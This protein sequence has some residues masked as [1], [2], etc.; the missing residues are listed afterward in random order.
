MDWDKW[1]RKRKE[2]GKDNNEDEFFGAFFDELGKEFERLRE[3][4]DRFFRNV[5]R[6]D[7]EILRERPFVYGFSMRIGPDGRPEI[8]EFGDRGWY[9]GLPTPTR[10]REPLT[11]VIEEKDSVAITVELPGVEK[12]DIDLTATDETLTIDVATAQ[13]KYHKEITLPCKVL[14]ETTE[15]TYKNGVLDIVIKKAVVKEEKKGKRIKIK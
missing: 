2:G 15:A 7:W 12:D 9:R 8:R 5:M 14:P 10:R 4:M 1:K 3:H 6:G 11:D 13:R